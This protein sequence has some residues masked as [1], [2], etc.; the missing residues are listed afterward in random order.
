MGD[1]VLKAVARKLQQGCREDAQVFRY[2]G[3]EFVV[4]MPGISLQKARHMAD[5]LRR[6]VEKIAVKDRRTGTIMGDIT[7]S[8]GVAQKTVKETPSEFVA[9]ADAMLYKAKNLGRNRVM[10]IG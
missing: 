4:L 5:V 1:L 7:V 8:A 9:R 2:G 10:P 3:E 6:T